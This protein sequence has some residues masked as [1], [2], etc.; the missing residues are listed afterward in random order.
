[1]EEQQQKFTE[2]LERG[3]RALVEQKD[4]K[5]ATAAFNEV[6]QPSSQNFN[7]HKDVII[8]A[9]LGHLISACET[10]N[11]ADTL[12]DARKLLKLLVTGPKTLNTELQTRNYLLRALVCQKSFDQTTE[13]E[14]RALLD[15]I[16]SSEYSAKLSSLASDIVEKVEK[17][18]KESGTEE[19]QLQDIQKSIQEINN[20]LLNEIPVDEHTKWLRKEE[21]AKKDEETTNK[22][23]LAKKLEN[24]MKITA[25]QKETN[26]KVNDG[27][28]CTYCGISFGDKSEL[29]LHCQTQEHQ[30]VLMSDE[31]KYLCVLRGE[32]RF[33]F[34]L[35][36]VANGNGVHH[37]GATLLNRIHYA[38]I[39]SRTP[40]VTT[41]ISVR[42]LMALKS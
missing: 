38:I 31:G 27:V 37:H 42:M 22:D 40:F 17:C 36:Q 11:Y 28:S 14:A 39:L 3:F 24:S 12:S 26:E 5:S 13:T 30:N 6:L 8:T 10:E 35:S 25:K 21:V 7:L 2:I 1:M 9:L 41:G 15:V 29:R 18:V 33:M 23:D 16:K 4:W 32:T 20:V 34:L 19:T